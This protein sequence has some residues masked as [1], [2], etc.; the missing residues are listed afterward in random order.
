VRSM[1][2]AR[3]RPGKRPLAPDASHWGQAR[4]RS[5][6]AYKCCLAEPRS[7]RKPCAPTRTALSKACG[8]T[9]W[10]PSAQATRTP[11]PPTLPAPP[12]PTSDS[13]VTATAT[14]KSCCS[15]KAPYR[16]GT[17]HIVMSPL[18]FLHRRTG[19][20]PQA[21]SDSLP[22]CARAAGQIK[23]P[24]RSE[25]APQ[26]PRGLRSSRPGR[27]RLSTRAHALGALGSKRLFDIDIGRRTRSPPPIRS[28]NTAARVAR[29]VRGRARAG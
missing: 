6:S 13:P 16:D 4:G 1:Q 12:L 27:A 28:R 15:S 7:P 29:A 2:T 3:S 14:A 22:W 10:P 23:S 17:T 18:E 9:L 5:C 19:A 11:M 25:R 26:P 20:T 24:D 21:A 8:A